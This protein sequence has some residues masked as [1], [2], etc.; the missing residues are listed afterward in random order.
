[1]PRRLAPVFPRAF[2]SPRGHQ[3]YPCGLPLV[4]SDRDSLV[5]A[6]RSRSGCFRILV[7]DLQA[8]LFQRRFKVTEYLDFADAVACA[9]VP[10]VQFAFERFVDAGAVFFI[11]ADR[12]GELVLFLVVATVDGA[13]WHARDEWRVFATVGVGVLCGGGAGECQQGR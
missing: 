10:G 2:D 9:V 11:D 4:A 3:H 6:S 13:T 7:H 5:A 12:N 1:M 8:T